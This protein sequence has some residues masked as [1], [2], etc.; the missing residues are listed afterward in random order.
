MPHPVSPNSLPAKVDLLLEL[1]SRQ[2]EVLLQLAD[3]E[4]R[5]E[6][7]LAESMIVVRPDQAKAA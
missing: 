7:A 3:L 2:D 1:E 4:R 5:V 6:R